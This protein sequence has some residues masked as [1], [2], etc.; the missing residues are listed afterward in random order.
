MLYV[1][2]IHRTLDE[3]QE[4]AIK[5]CKYLKEWDESY[6]IGKT[7]SFISNGREII[8]DEMFDEFIK[9]YWEE[10]VCENVARFEVPVIDSIELTNELAID[11]LIWEFDTWGFEDRIF[12]SENLF[13]ETQTIIDELTISYLGTIIGELEWAMKEAVKTKH[14]N[15]I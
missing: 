5:N 14:I 12:N 10:C 9:Y 4:R 6:Y 13:I 3:E 2:D 1:Y 8:A 15:W 11:E 7:K